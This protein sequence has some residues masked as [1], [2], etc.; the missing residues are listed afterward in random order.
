M[1]FQSASSVNSAIKGLAI[2][3][4]V[5]VHRLTGAWSIPRLV[6]ARSFLFFL[7]CFFAQRSV[8]IGLQA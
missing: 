7:K 3:Y 2:A 6:F 5:S 8:G 1:R 4:T